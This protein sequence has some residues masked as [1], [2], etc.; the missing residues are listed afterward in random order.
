[1]KPPERRFKVTPAQDK[2]S[3]GEDYTTWK[4]PGLPAYHDGGGVDIIEIAV[5]PG[6]KEIGLVYRARNLA[7]AERFYLL[8]QLAAARPQRAA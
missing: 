7:D 4:G 3:I 2:V 6:E 1:M 5:T 8:Q